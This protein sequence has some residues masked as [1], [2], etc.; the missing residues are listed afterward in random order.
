MSRTSEKGWPD[1]ARRHLEEAE[2][3]GAIT[4]Q[5]VLPVGQLAGGK[6]QGST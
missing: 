6:R 2:Q 1:A 3:P 5:A 4:L